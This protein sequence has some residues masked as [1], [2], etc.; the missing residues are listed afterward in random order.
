MRLG[1][2][3]HRIGYEAGFWVKYNCA[4]CHDAGMASEREGKIG[5]IYYE[6]LGT[7]TKLPAK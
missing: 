3:V 1:S 4:C 5:H 2:F 6:A 7:M